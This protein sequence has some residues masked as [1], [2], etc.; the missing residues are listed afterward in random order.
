[1]TSLFH[2]SEIVEV[3]LHIEQNGGTFY[4]LL[5]DKMPNPSVKEL[6]QDLAQE[7]RK[8]F[9]TFQ[10]ILARDGHWEP[11]GTYA[12]EY[13]DYMDCLV[14][15][16]VFTRENTAPQVTEQIVDEK[17][18][19]QYARAI[20]KDSILFYMEMKESVPDKERCIIEELIEEEKKHLT[21]LTR[22]EED[23]DKNGR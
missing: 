1:M 20:E 12:A 15:H 21:R 16:N 22:I 17:K 2:A 3:A 14:S 4:G 10:K 8:H 7:E 9:E 19:L 18:A 5:A 6:F 13:R 23:L 11:L